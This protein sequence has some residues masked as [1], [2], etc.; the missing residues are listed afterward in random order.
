MKKW[1]SRRK[2]WVKGGILAGTVNIVLYIFYLTIYLPIVG[3]FFREMPPD[4]VWILPMITGH[5]FVFM[6]GF[7]VP[8]D[9]FCSFTQSVCT[10]WSQSPVLNGGIPW[11][12]DGQSGYCLMQTMTPTNACAHASEIITF[13][14]GALVLLGIY[15]L[16]GFLLGVYLDKRKKEQK[17]S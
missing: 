16:V 12:M 9:L 14:A 17:I 2:T 15:V 6:S 13:F 1:F 5:F 4:G 3:H 7:F 11:T 10:E 8:Y